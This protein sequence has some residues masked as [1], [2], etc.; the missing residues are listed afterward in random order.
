MCKE[1]ENKNL[2]LTFFCVLALPLI[3]G[4]CCT[5]SLSRGSNRSSSSRSSSGDWAKRP[6][7]LLLL[8]FLQTLAAIVAFFLSH[9]VLVR[10]LCWY[11]WAYM[12]ICL[13]VCVIASIFGL[14]LCLILCQ[15]E[16]EALS[17]LWHTFIYRM[18]YTYICMCV[19][20]CAVAV[21]LYNWC[22][23]HVHLFLPK[24]WQPL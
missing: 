20:V 5:V 7:P 14:L 18:L 2:R 17:L 16:E 1:N 4:V 13:C 15:S 23:F 9:K 19:W 21:K 24:F 8:L 10:R 3:G 22:Y 6:C 12:R 11:V